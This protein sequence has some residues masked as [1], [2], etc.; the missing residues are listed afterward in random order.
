M[1]GLKKLIARA[2]ALLARAN[3]GMIRDRSPKDEPAAQSINPP[4]SD[5][6]EAEQG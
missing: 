1:S 5:S 4:S 6:H 2:K 3:R